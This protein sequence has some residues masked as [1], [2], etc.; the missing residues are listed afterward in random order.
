MIA[1][2]KRIS[3]L[4]SLIITSTYTDKVMTVECRKTIFSLS[5]IIIEII[6]HKRQ[7]CWSLKIKSLK[8]AEI[9]HMCTK[10]FSDSFCYDELINQKHSMH[11]ID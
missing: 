1:N 5:I 8:W 10:F 4:T 11:M 2:I 3:P 9:I 6:L 7:F